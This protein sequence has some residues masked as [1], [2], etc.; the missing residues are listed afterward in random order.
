MCVY[1]H[2]DVHVFVW[3]DAHTRVCAHVHVPHPFNTP[4]SR[5]LDSLPL[6]PDS[7]T[8]TPRFLETR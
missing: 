2:E 5:P 7:K 6:D 4:P 8:S 1:V 3:G